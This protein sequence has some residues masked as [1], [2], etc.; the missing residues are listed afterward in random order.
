MEYDAV[1]IL[2]KGTW[3][4]ITGVDASGAWVEIAVVGME[5]PVWVARNLV[6]TVSA[7]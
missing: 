3:A 1:T 4:R 2:P 7:R 5:R 6:K